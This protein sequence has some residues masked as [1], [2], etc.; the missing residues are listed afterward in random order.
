MMPARTSPR[1]IRAIAGWLGLGLGL[2]ALHTIWSVS[3]P[4]MASPDEPSH[5]VR[6]AA[7]ARGQWSGELGAPPTDASAPGAATTVQ[8]PSD[9]AQVV[10]LPNCFAFH[11]DQPASCQQT[12]TPANGS[13]AP[14]AT[15]AGQYPPL[16]YAL[17]GWPSRFLSA[18]SSIYA[19]RIVSGVIASAFLLWGAA[20]LRTTTLPAAATWATLVAITPMTL[21]MGATVNP[22]ALEISSAVAFWAACLALARS[23]GAPGRGALVQ[24]VV[25]GGVLV[26]SRTSGPV[27]AV[28][29]V[30]VALVLAPRGRVRQL[31]A[32]RSMRWAVGAAVAAGLAAT[33]WV[34]THG[35]VVTGHH[36][37]PQYASP[38]R[39]ARA[40]LSETHA[41][42]LQMIGDFGW[43]DAPSP[44]L[45]TVLWFVAAGALLLVGLAVDG[46]RR[47]KVA[48]VLAALAVVAAP[49]VLQIPTAADTGIIWQGRY[50]LPAAVGVP[51]VAAAALTGRGLDELVRRMARWVVPAVAVAQVAAFWWAMRRYSEG[52]AGSLLT[53]SPHWSSPLGYLSAVAL[54]AVVVAAVTGAAWFSLRPDR[55]TCERPSNGT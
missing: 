43:L 23:D 25:A 31:W 24:A 38:L 6:A 20:R 47:V 1:R 14:V 54:Y 49:V 5:V 40:I 50:T 55:T 34:A 12:V 15:F 7:V 22:E 13:T 39:V 42:F 28:V 29:I 44:P 27:W 17:V 51:M 16:Y 3:I 48:L 30:V 21:F 53:R 18:E 2:V 26:N 10:K 4:L 32:A 46:P 35:G 9:Y 8:L 52:L 41:Y 45:T 33:A 36:L 19:M 11:P 37:F